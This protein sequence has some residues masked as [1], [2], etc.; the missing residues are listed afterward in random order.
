MLASPTEKY[1]FKPFVGE[2]GVSSP[3]TRRIW[4]GFHRRLSLHFKPPPPG[5]CAHG[6]APGG[7]RQ[8]ERVQQSDFYRVQFDRRN[9]VGRAGEAIWPFGASGRRRRFWLRWRGLAQLGARTYGN[10]PPR[11]ARVRA[12]AVPDGQRPAGQGQ[13][14]VG[15]QGRRGPRRSWTEGPALSQVQ[16]SAGRRGGAPDGRAVHLSVCF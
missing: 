14:H 9:R 7:D 12:C 3:G 10:K 6:K 11:R 2:K 1:S 8:L 13:T 15:D 5:I 16:R 4:L